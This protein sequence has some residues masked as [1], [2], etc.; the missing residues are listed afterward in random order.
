MSR[1]V[2]D[3]APGETQLTLLGVRRW[4]VWEKGVSTFPWEYFEDETSYIVAGHAI[5]TPEGARPWKSGR[6]IWCGSSPG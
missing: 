6:V 1:I 2:V 4:P 5:V 3:P